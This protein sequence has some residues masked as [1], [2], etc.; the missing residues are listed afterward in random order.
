LLYAG[1]TIQFGLSFWYLFTQ[2]GAALMYVYTLLYSAISSQIHG[3]VMWRGTTYSIDEIRLAA[4][5]SGRKGAD[6]Q[7]GS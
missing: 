1:M 3:G 4:A 7:L 5:E 6:R 2:P